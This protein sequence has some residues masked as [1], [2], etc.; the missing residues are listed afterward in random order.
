MI[1]NT[2]LFLGLVAIA[3]VV[4]SVSGDAVPELPNGRGAAVYREYCFRCHGTNGEGGEGRYPIREHLLVSMDV[5]TVISTIAFGAS[6][7]LRP[8]DQG[9]RKGM[10]PAPYNDADVAE[11]TAYVMRSIAKRSVTIT[12]EDV[13]RVKREHLEALRRRLGTA[14]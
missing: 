3:A 12:A 5:D 14:N 8:N 7:A 9:V 4:W 13:A 10:P 11:V 1:R 6:G 2:A